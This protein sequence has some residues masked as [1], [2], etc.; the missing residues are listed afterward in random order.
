MKIFRFLLAS[1]FCLFSSQVSADQ[2]DGNFVNS[3]RT[4]HSLSCRGQVKS[5]GSVTVRLSRNTL[6]ELLK[7]MSDRGYPLTDSV[8]TNSNRMLRTFDSDAPENDEFVEFILPSSNDQCEYTG[9]DGAEREFRPAERCSRIKAALN[10][11]ISVRMDEAVTSELKVS[12]ATSFSQYSWNQIL[13]LSYDQLDQE[14]VDLNRDFLLALSESNTFPNPTS[15]KDFNAEAIAVAMAHSQQ[16]FPFS[17]EN[18][19]EPSA[20]AAVWTGDFLQ[21]SEQAI[22]AYQAMLRPDLGPFSKALPTEALWFEAISSA[23]EKH[24]IQA[25]PPTFETTSRYAYFG[26]GGVTSFSDYQ[27]SVHDLSPYTLPL[28]VM[29]ATGKNPIE[30][31]HAVVQSIGTGAFR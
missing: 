16:I 31:D 8:L 18:A 30:I 13:S 21:I 27:S 2:C 3:S 25:L 15:H 5:D 23:L 1:S 29:A 7:I 24:G 11:F 9:G 4:E 6:R 26:G 17:E 14:D 12:M 20:G 19:M 28:N 22:G 10:Y